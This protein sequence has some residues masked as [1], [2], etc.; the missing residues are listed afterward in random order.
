MNKPPPPSQQQADEAQRARHAAEMVIL[1]L[2]RSV[3]TGGGGG[4]E[5]TSVLQ[6]LKITAILATLSSAI[7]AA[8]FRGALVSKPDN[9][10][11]ASVLLDD[12]QRAFDELMGSDLSDEQRAV[13]WATWAY[14]RV[15]ETIAAAVDEDYLAPPDILQSGAKL[16]KVWISR[17]DVRVRPL[18]ARLHGKTVP[19]EA[20]FWRWPVTG[21]RL[22][23]P[24]DRD[25]PPEATIGC[26]CVCLLS[27]ASQSDTSESIQ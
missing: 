12:A 15:A 17:S 13:L 22:R 25:A 9:D 8:S 23:W 24:G 27:W 4:E 16:K 20:D 3:E 7:V 11:V 26:R 5:D 2:F 18:H 19:V 14:S 6:G 10:E 1:S 21:H